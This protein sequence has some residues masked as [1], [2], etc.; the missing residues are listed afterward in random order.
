M[1]ADLVLTGGKIVTSDDAFRIAEAVA[2]SDGKVAAV[3]SSSEISALAGQGTQRID[4]GGRTVIPGLID[5]HAHMDNEGLKYIFPSLAGCRSVRDIQERIAA[6]AAAAKPGEWIVTMP[7]GDP[8][9]YRDMPERLLEGRYPNRWELDA[10]A[11][12]NPVYIK[13]VYG[14]WRGLGGFPLASVANSRALQ[15]AGVTRDTLPP[16][17]G[18]QIDRELATGEPTGVFYEWTPISVVELT[19][20]A[21]VPR[22]T[23]EDRLSALRTSM[24][25]YNASGTTSVVETHGV[26]PE[27]LHAYRALE[28]AGLSSVRAHLMI[29]PGWRSN[30]ADDVAEL[31]RDWYGWCAGRGLGNDMLRV[32]GMYTRIGGGAD[33]AIRARAMPYT[34]WSGFAP[35]SEI[36]REMVREL[37][38]EAARNGMRVTTLYTDL[39]DLFEEA[40]KVKSIADNRWIISH[41]RSLTPVE[42]ERIRDLGI[43]LTLN[44]NRWI[45]DQGSAVRARLGPGREDEIVP[46]RRLI[47]AGVSFSL[48]TDNVPTSLFHPLEHCVSRRNA[49]TGEIIAPAQ[50]LSREEAL[51]AATRG[52]AYLTFEEDVKGAL[53]PGKLADLAVLSDD[54]LSVPEERIKDIRSLLTLVGGRV[55][56][57]E[58]SGPALDA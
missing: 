23:Y 54:L 5:G 20:M 37:V 7:I 14:Y 6:L 44:T 11:P 36:P 53:E 16:W 41:V 38:L 46:L 32:G 31:M 9:H 33:A 29:S 45:A 40:D 12:D 8:P 27:V 10:V 17:S 18:I 52:G 2:I 39:L 49:R 26:V 42:I 35:N 51:R 15:L 48:A 3:G 56:H 57:R 43:A 24:A 58:E 13:P 30:D 47:D 21:L 1:R 50:K 4:L 55:V 25:I 28:Q 34:S 19:L 22:F